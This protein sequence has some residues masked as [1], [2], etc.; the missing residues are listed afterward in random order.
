MENFKDFLRV[1]G[2]K[3]AF[4][5]S[6]DLSGNC[7]SISHLRTF[8]TGVQVG[9]HL[10]VDHVL[11]AFTFWVCHRY[12]IPMGGLDGIG[13]ILEHAGGDEATAFDLFFKL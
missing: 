1:V 3:P 6:P 11:D 4:Y 7:K 13:Y 8:L 5:L 9:Q 2:K 12:Q 10:Q